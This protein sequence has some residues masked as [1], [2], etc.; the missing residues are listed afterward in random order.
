MPVNSKTK[1]NNDPIR[2][3]KGILNKNHFFTTEENIKSF[4][5]NSPLLNNINIIIFKI[6]VYS[7][8]Q[9]STH[10]AYLMCTVFLIV[11]K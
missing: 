3:I 4:K 7:I 11:I 8:I 6:C 5:R 2:N 9:G 10:L 1:W